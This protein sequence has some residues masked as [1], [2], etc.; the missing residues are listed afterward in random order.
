[1][2]KQLDKRRRQY[3]GEKAGRDHLEKELRA[4]IDQQL[5]NENGHFIQPIG[6]LRSCYSE[7]VGTPRQGH[8]APSTRAM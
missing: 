4:V 2:Q 6:F 1:M 7:C 5:T 8:L 3:L